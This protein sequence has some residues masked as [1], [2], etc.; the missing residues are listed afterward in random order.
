LP[1]T[2]AKNLPERVD[3]DN[4]KYKRINP[5]AL[6]ESKELPAKKNDKT[7]F[8]TTNSIREIKAN[9]KRALQNTNKVISGKSNKEEIAIIK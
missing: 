5:R 8:I 3:N 7:Q 1:E 6:G 4:V 9:E 2:K